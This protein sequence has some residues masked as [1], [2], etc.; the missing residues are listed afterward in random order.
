V[1]APNK[2][3]TRQQ[4]SRAFKRLCKKCGLQ[5]EPPPRLHDLR[6]NYASECLIQWQHDCKDIETLLPVLSTAMG[7]V[8]PCATQRYIHINASTLFDAS[9]KIHARFTQPTEE[10]Q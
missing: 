7:H 9:G 2:R 8:N 6:H 1:S 5:G 4:A 10:N 3:L